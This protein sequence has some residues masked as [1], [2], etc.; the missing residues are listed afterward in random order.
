[1]KP[2]YCGAPVV[3]EGDVDPSPSG[4]PRIRVIFE[5]GGEVTLQ[6]VRSRHN[7]R[8]THWRA[9]TRLVCGAHDF[10]EGDVL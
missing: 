5:C 6:L 4:A 9:C 7:R 3:S 2:C 10:D 8:Q 1:M